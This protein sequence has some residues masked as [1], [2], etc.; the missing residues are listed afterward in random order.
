MKGIIYSRLKWYNPINLWRVHKLA[1]WFAEGKPYKIWPCFEKDEPN[2][3]VSERVYEYAFAVDCANKVGP[4]RALDVGSAGSVLPGI[5]AKFSKELVALDVR[6]WKPTIPGLTTIRAD[7]NDG[8]PLGVFDM[9]YC[10]STLE[11]I[12][13][14]RYGD[15]FDKEGDIRAMKQIRTMLCNKGLVVIT[16]PYGRDEINYP[17]HRIYDEA[18]FMRLTEGFKLLKREFYC[19]GINGFEPCARGETIGSKP[20][21]LVCALLEAEP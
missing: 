16:V 12:G 11:H 14:G 21:G 18:R 10:I 3:K 1:Q 8:R 4:D 20:F 5:L 6:E 2:L 17:A 13:L 15:S 19:N 9:I 7:I